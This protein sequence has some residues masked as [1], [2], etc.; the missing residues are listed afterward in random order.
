MSTLIQEAATDTRASSASPAREA[1]VAGGVRAVRRHHLAVICRWILT[2]I[3]IVVPVFVFSTLITFLLGTLSGINP[4]AGIAGDEASPEVIA[5][6]EAQFGLDLPVWQQ[7]LNWMAGIFRGDLGTS[8]F[9][10]VPVSELIGQRLAVSASVAGL[11]LL[12]G[13]VSGVVLGLVAAI[14]RGRPVDRAVT[15]F[16]SVVSTLPPFVI[17]IGLIVVFSLWLRLLPSAGYA[18][19][20]QGLWPWLSFII[21]PALALSVDVTADIARQLRT[22]MV[23][24]LSQN[25]ITGATVRGLGRSRILFGHALRNGSGP[26]LAILGMKI[27]T[28][29]GGAVVT[30]TIFSMPGFG[31]L[32]AD[33]ALR[34]D[35]PVVQGTLVVAIV[36]VLFANVIVN[37]VQVSLQ[38]ASR[39]RG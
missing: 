19:L 36:F 23:D 38:P 2:T 9:N 11:A 16:T 7:Y 22:G 15:G 4:A 3:A 26:A 33:S 20:S 13:L 5:R 39:R 6:I 10:R 24:A 31:V 14:N 29:L 25:Y 21:M 34:G 27:P 17:G 8:W 30:E 32:S 1:T 28:L 35:V 12:I 18:P 37:I